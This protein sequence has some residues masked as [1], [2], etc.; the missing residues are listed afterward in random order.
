M[1]TIVIIIP[2][3]INTSKFA[4]IC[5]KRSV[6]QSN[7]INENATKLTKNGIGAGREVDIFEADSKTRVLPQGKTRAGNYSSIVK[8]RAF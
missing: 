5:V 2:L 6:S 7:R 1:K 3:K 4:A 8:I